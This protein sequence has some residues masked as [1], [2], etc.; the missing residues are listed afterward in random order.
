M[1]VFAFSRTTVVGPN[2]SLPPPYTHTHTAPSSPGTRCSTAV[3]LGFILPFFVFFVCVCVCVCVWSRSSESFSPN[4]TETFAVNRTLLR[5]FV[6]VWVGSGRFLFGEYRGEGFERQVSE[7]PDASAMDVE[8]EPFA[9]SARSPSADTW[10][11]YR[12]L[13]GFF[14]C[15]RYDRPYDRFADGV[16]S[17]LTGFLPSFPGLQFLRLPCETSMDL[18]RMDFTGLQLDFYWVLLG[19]I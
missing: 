9:P 13:P 14:F 10:V 18:V 12:V 1:D 8:R 6:S 3:G 19:F 2:A 17:A 5:N 11:N 16:V 15:A 7:M 4:T